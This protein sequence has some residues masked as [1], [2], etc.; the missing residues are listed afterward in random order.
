MY[1]PALC[2]SR[3]PW[4]H[5]DHAR[6]RSSLMTKE[7]AATVL[8]NQGR[9]CVNLLHPKGAPFQ[10]DSSDPGRCERPRPIPRSTPTG[11]R[12]PA[13]R[14]DL[15]MTQPRIA[16]VTGGARGKGASPAEA[17][18]LGWPR[19]RGRRVRRC[20]PVRAVARSS[21]SPRPQHTG[22]RCRRPVRPSP[23][24]QLPPRCCGACHV[25]PW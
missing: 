6:A 18:A 10:V 7:L 2:V 5:P 23:M 12:R 21:I 15:S 20:S 24:P 17:L 13:V 8:P 9:C 1:R 14:K 22:P 25:R 11:C 19:G 4:I 16:L 3:C